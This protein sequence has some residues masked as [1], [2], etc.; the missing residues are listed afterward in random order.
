[1]DDFSAFYNNAVTFKQLFWYINVGYLV[2]VWNRYYETTVEIEEARR[3]LTEKN[4]LS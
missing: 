3:M 2:T 1:M 4:I